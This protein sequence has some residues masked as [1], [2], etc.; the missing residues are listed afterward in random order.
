[1]CITWPKQYEQKWIKACLDFGI[2][3]RK[4]NIPI[5]TRYYEII[6]LFN[7][8][9]FVNFCDKNANVI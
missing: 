2:L 8:Q 5:K 6:Q 7:Y 9:S 4:L 1:M 3:L